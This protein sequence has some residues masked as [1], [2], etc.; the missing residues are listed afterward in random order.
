MLVHRGGCESSDRTADADRG[1]A[2]SD[3]LEIYE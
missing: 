3:F 2:R 1:R